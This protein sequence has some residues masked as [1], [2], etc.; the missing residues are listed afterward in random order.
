MR[1]PSKLPETSQYLPRIKFLNYNKKSNIHCTSAGVS[2][3][4]MET[5]AIASPLETFLQQPNIETSPA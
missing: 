4:T 2:Q 1:S 5:I 3:A